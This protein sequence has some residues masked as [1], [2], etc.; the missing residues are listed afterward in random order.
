L[1]AGEGVDGVE[2]ESGILRKSILTSFFCTSLLP[3]SIRVQ[4]HIPDDI[5]TAVLPLKYLRWNV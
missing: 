2:I 5:P 1:L 4:N 3:P